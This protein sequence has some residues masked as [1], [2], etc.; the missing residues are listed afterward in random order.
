MINKEMLISR[1]DQLSEDDIVSLLNA[2]KR[3]RAKENRLTI[4]L[5]ASAVL[6]RLFLIC[7][8][9]CLWHYS[10]SLK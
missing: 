9:K 10:N 7:G 2:S 4:P 8:T 3:I 6:T 5:E 1:I